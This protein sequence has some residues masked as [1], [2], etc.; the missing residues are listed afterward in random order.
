MSNERTPINA[1]VVGVSVHAVSSLEN[2]LNQE[3]NSSDDDQPSSPL[4]K[5]LYERIWTTCQSIYGTHS[6]LVKALI[7]I[8]I[9]FAYPPLGATYL[10]PQITA[11]WI[12]VIF[13][14]ILA[15]MGIKTEEFAKAFQRLR[16]NL[17]VQIFNFGVVSSIVFGFS[18]FMVS[19]DA[20]TQSLADGMIICA[21]LPITINMVLVLTKSAGGDEAAAIF[22]AAFGNL[23]GI[24]LSPALI[25][26][27]L[28]VSG[29]VNLGDVFF[30]LGLRV[31]L[32]IFIGQVLQHFVPPAK[33]FV[34][35]YKK[36]FKAAQEWCLLFIIYTVF[37]KT[38]L[39][40]MEADGK[41]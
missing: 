24:F 40:G 2:A 32:P 11:T 31:V 1:S 26:G 25:L 16:F 30:K 23:V 27:Y 28:G 36:H 17:F 5:P 13:I 19:V 7:L 9:A 15:G 3:N 29:Q 20:L 22:N 21:S 35:Q 4:P 18:K 33:E 41:L 8:L 10:A 39:E 38:F 12:A 14:F 37:C 34:K 6:F